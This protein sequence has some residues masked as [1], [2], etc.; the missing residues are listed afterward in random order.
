MKTPSFAIRFLLIAGGLFPLVVNAA[1]TWQTKQ[2]DLRAMAGTTEIATAFY[3]RNTGDT[4]VTIASLR[5]SCD[6][7]TATIDK[8][9]YAAGERGR[10]EVRF[11]PGER[12]GVAERTIT[13]TMADRSIVTMHLRVN[14]VEPVSC[15][16]QTLRWE[17]NGPASEQSAQ[18]VAIPPA[19]IHTIDLGENDLGKFAR[20][21]IE[22]T[23]TSRRYRLSIIPLDLQRP[24]TIPLHCRIEFTDGSI[25]RLLIS[26]VIK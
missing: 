18:I 23:E 16:P 4:P 2:L 6:C 11:H 15:K 14:L 12:T 17:K 22:P 1:L 3:F 5:T 19:V 9:D 24:R 20:V 21:C 8:P 10:I 13:V 7:T 26:T 25:R